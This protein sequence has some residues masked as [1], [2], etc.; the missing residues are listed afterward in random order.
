[1]GGLE[2]ESSCVKSPLPDHAVVM[3]SCRLFAWVLLLSGAVS[4]GASPH[5]R[6]DLGAHD[7]STIIKCK[8]RYYQVVT[9]YGI[10]TKS[11]ADKV[12][13]KSGPPVFSKLPSWTTNAVPGFDGTVW[14]P[15]IIY[16]ANAY[17]VYYAISTWGSQTSAIGMVS[18]PTL[19]PTDP[20]YAWTDHG[21]VILSSTTSPYN[22]IDPSLV[23]DASG[24]PWMCFG[25]Y[26]TGIYVVQLDPVT[27]M[28]I[29]ADSPTTQLAYNSSIEASCLFHRGGYYYLFV[30]YDS[31]CSGVNSGYNIRVG[32]SPTITGPYF[33]RAGRDMRN[34]GNTLFLE[35]TG[36]FTGPGHAGILS[37]GGR[38]YLSYHY[39]DANA[40][41]PWYGAYGP[42]RFDLVPLAWTADN[43]P[44]YTND[45]SAL[46]NFEFDATDD[47]GQYSGMLRGTARTV[48]DPTYG[49][50]LSLE[51]TN[52][53][54]ELPPGVAYART[55]S[56]VVKWSGG[57]PWQRI[58]DFGTDTSR[59]V[60][61]TPASGDRHM[62]CDIRTGA[63]YSID[64]PTAVPTNRWTHVAVTFDDQRGILYLNGAPVA[65]N[66]SLPVAPLLV[67]A[68]TNHLGRSKFAADANFNG[69]IAGFRAHGRVLNA[70]SITAPE[71]RI[72]LPDSKSTFLP[73]TRV[74][75]RGS[76][77]DF[78]LTPLGPSSCQWQIDIIRNGRTN[79]LSP[80]LIGMTNTSFLVPT[81][82]PGDATL[83]VRL[84]VTDSIGRKT[85]AVAMVPSANP[86]PDW[87]ARHPLQS[88]AL[89]ARGGTAGLL[90]GGASFTNDP[91]RG[92]VLQLTGSGQYVQLPQESSRFMTFSAWVKWSGGA[93]SQ[94]V[95]DFGTDANRHS[96]LTPRAAGGKLRF[97]MTLRGVPGDLI[98]EAPWALPT[99]LWVHLAVVL[100]GSR[101]VL[102]TNGTPVATNAALNITS[103]NLGATN[104]YLGRSLG[105]DPY[106]RGFISGVRLTS[107]AIPAA[108][109]LAPLAE[110]SSPGPGRGCEPGQTISFSGSALDYRDRMIAPTG[111]TWTVRHILNGV[112]N[113]VL[114]PVQGVSSGSYTVPLSGTMSTNGL[115]RFTLEAVDLEGRKSTNWVDL[116]PLASVS[117]AGVEWQ[118]FY[119]FT[120]DARDASNRFAGTLNG[121]ASVQIEAIRSRVLNLSG[122][123]QYLSLPTGSSSAQTI[124]SWVKWRGGAA[125]QRI[126]DWGVDTEHWFYFTPFNGGGN[127]ECGITSDSTSFAHYMQPNAPFPLNVWTHVAVSLNGREAVVYTN[128]V[129][130]IVNNAVYVLPSDLGAT[131]V[132]FGRSMFPADAYFNG[133][134]DSIQ[135]NSLGLDY[136]TLFAPTPAILQPTAGSSFAGGDAISFSGSAS[137]F[138]GNAI[139]VTN[140]NWSA[141]LVQD[142]QVS[143]VA[144]AWSNA[145]T[146]TLTIPGTGPTST[147]VQYRLALT[148]SA[149]NGISSTTSL[150]ISPKVLPVSFETAPSGLQI[151][152]DGYPTQTPV[153]VPMVQGWSREVSAPASQPFAGSNYLFVAWSDL[154]DPTHRITPL[155][156]KTNHVA[157]YVRP[158]LALGSRD[159]QLALQWPGWAA[160]MPV[161]RAESLPSPPQAWIRLTNTAGY[162]NGLSSLI[163]PRGTPAGFYRLGM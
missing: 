28:R 15:D 40:Y 3:S 121:G 27:G 38:Q 133:Q 32:R 147:N 161:Y 37:E 18:T 105:P 153:T 35:G 6:G 69:L 84:L 123:G 89:D 154:G 95:F 148:A 49:R 103:E 55:F 73:G 72:E 140:W 99:N 109:I 102:Y 67:R 134:L 82:T 139:P 47:H 149:T 51:G 88:N 26:W 59:Y 162:S 80:L 74:I 106:F 14:A 98:I 128:G 90:L 10:K 53:S 34:A 126:F 157:G 48:P 152:L 23:L 68:Q 100:D 115:Y 79:V 65:T 107:R 31:C 124:S 135:M 13:W 112:T 131:R 156:E 143:T 50:V 144:G 101:G 58:F 77:R 92:Q 16:F 19:D 141:S 127:M 56:A 85:T 62:R 146:G 118:S 136:E 71:A 138:A 111:M 1:M 114:G 41:A 63:T 8:D 2:I 12:F 129:P 151:T 163:L 142:G 45:W 70:Q 160:G 11:S 44:V 122:T 17:R 125:W 96:V 64:A 108:Q 52:A 116:L 46:Y 78:M 155:P 94:P 145:A 39:Y 137:D 113:T 117:S 29:S 7:P 61:L 42:A 54:V 22:V 91:D 43:W 57:A 25:S 159:G 75:L 20:A 5:L 97:N 83:Q 66:S 110:I 120:L 4:F 36:K 33:D 60:M 93:D 132:W 30:N 87:D 158:T 86:A 130:A 104:F 76:G 21:P 24:N 150:D 81:N 119:P 9:G